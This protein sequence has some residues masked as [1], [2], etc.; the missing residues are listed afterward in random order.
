MMQKCHIPNH[1]HVK[2]QDRQQFSW[3]G[4]EVL[5]SQ[6]YVTCCLG[7]TGSHPSVDVELSPLHLHRP[8]FSSL[9]PHELWVQQAG[10]TVLQVL[11]PT[12]TVSMENTAGIHTVTEWRGNMRTSPSPGVPGEKQIFP[13]KKWY[14]MS[15]TVS[16]LISWGQWIQQ[17]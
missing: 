16:G 15:I 3:S 7:S 14:I 6:A 12:S 5:P 13:N 1:R 4:Q 10:C 17:K 11:K 8:A 9:A 2:N